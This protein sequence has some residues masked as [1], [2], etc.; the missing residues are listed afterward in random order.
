MGRQ[1]G[2]TEVIF[3]QSQVDEA[4]KHF[5]PDTAKG[6]IAVAAE[7]LFC[8]YATKGVQTQLERM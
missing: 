7:K 6:A 5:L 1:K 2:S 3:D 4:H 8:E